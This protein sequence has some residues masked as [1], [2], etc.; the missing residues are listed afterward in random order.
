MTARKAGSHNQDMTLLG[1]RIRR[2]RQDRGMTLAAIAKQVG[3]SVALLSQIEND[4]VMPSVKT[5]T[6]IAAAMR[7]QPGVFFEETHGDEIITFRQ[8]GEREIIDTGNEAQTIELLARHRI[9][10]DREVATYRFELPVGYTEHIESHVHGGHELLYC[11][12]GSLDIK[13][14]QDTFLLDKGCS[15]YFFAGLPHTWRNVADEVTEV[16]SVNWP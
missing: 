6:G 2:I 1:S 9:D 3:C 14:G 8:P 12:R 7:V 15:L 5:L 16:I 10:A 4:K 13:V 11:V